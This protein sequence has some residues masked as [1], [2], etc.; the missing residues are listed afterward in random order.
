MDRRRQ[1]RQETAFTNRMISKSTD[2]LEIDAGILEQKRQETALRN[3]E[4]GVN[5]ERLRRKREETDLANT[6][7]DV[8]AEEAIKKKA[9]N[10]EDA[11]ILLPKRSTYTLYYEK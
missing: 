7:M 1:K 8:D 5:A 6:E 4:L 9:R 10:D 11:V 2:Q 3:A